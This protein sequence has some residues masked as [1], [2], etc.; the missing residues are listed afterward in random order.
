MKS[1]EQLALEWALSDDTGSSSEAICRHMTGVGRGKD[2]FSYPSDPG[3]LG[4]CLRLL[5]IVPEWKPRM[6][7]M[8]AHGPGWSGLAFKWDNLAQMM[9][10]EV[11]IDW[12]KGGRAPKTYHA[13]K[14]AIADGYRSD[15]RYECTFDSNG[16]LSMARLK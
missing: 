14:L 9:T 15:P 11:G 6:Q 13:M 3:D 2:C 12:S 7:E 10:E 5:E 8:A 4:R 16:H 1:I